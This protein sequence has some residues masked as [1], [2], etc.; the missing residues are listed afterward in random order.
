MQWIEGVEAVFGYSYKGRQNVITRFSFS[1]LEAF[2]TLIPDVVTEA[3]RL[4][5][6]N[7]YKSF[8]LQVD[9]GLALNHR[10]SYS[11]FTA[12]W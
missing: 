7:K 1:S 11:I 4:N 9:N 2:I 10:F 8:C 6:S 12:C 3:Y 5:I